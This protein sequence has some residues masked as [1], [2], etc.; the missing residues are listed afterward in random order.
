MS[1]ALVRLGKKLARG[2]VVLSPTELA[3]IRALVEGNNQSAV[4]NAALYNKLIETERKAGLALFDAKALDLP[5]GDTIVVKRYR[6]DGADRLSI[7]VDVRVKGYRQR[8]GK[9]RGIGLATEH[10]GVV[11]LFLFFAYRA[12]PGGI[13]LT[14][15]QATEMTRAVF[16]S[17]TPSADRLGRLRRCKRQYA[18]AA[19]G[20][21]SV[22][23]LFRVIAPA[24]LER[25]AAKAMA[26]LQEAELS[27]APGPKREFARAV[28]EIEKRVALLPP[29]EE[30]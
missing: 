26:L 18:A 23:P 16:P 15:R 19:K 11:A 12:Q 5:T 2:T 21:E 6:W 20:D 14:E 9:P 29:M 25:S 4:A 24:I 3:A 10:P 30:R 22:D 27:L 28:A 17:E 1:K 8:R 13:R 7:E